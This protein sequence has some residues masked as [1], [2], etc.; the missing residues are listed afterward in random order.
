MRRSDTETSYHCLSCGI[1]PFVFSFVAAGT[2][3]GAYFSGNVNIDNVD[4]LDTFE[5]YWK[6]SDTC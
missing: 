3:P 1:F 4:S 2:K 6:A 5:V